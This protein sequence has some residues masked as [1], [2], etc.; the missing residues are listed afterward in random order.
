MDYVE[1]RF[2]LVIK[3]EYW[4]GEEWNLLKGS[5]EVNF[6]YTQNTA[7]FVVEGGDIDSSDFYFNIQDCD[8]KDDL[9]CSSLIDIEL[10]LVDAKNEV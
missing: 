10:Y 1:N 2:M 9:L 8:W 7:I 4:T 5:I 6:C 3:D